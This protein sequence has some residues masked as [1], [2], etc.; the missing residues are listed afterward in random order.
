MQPIAGSDEVKLQQSGFDYSGGE[1]TA[2]TQNPA[3]A[4]FDI[5]KNT[6]ANTASLSQSSQAHTRVYMWQYIAVPAGGAVPPN[7]APWQ[8]AFSTKSKI[9]IT[10]LLSDSPY[11]FRAASYS[12]DG[13]INWS[14]AKKY[15]VQ[16]S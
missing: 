9:T 15:T 13:I 12:A 2:V 14:T 3:P 16:G 11:Y 4:V 10:G 6:P 7:N 5:D 8:W 1:T